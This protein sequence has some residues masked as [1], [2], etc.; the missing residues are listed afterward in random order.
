MTGGP[1]I[2]IV[3]DELMIADYL[4]ET[5]QDAGFVVCGIAR[6]GAEAIALARLHH[7]A[8]SVIDLRLSNGEYGTGVGAALSEQS[9]IG[10]LYATGNSRHPLLDNAVG[11]ACISKPYTSEGIVAGVKIVLERIAKATQLSAFPAGFRLLNG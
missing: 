7:P 2:L 6:N 10:I 9:D 5:L 3:E 1:T 4:E 11:Q 8:L